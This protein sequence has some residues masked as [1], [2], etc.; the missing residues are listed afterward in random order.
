M[1]AENNT[2]KIDNHSIKLSH[3]NKILFPKSKISKEDVISY[4]AKI[5]NYFLPFVKDHLIVM[6]RFPDGI[7][8]DGFY[9]KQIPNFF[10]KWIA[11]KQI[12]LKKGEKQSLV[13]IDQKAS[14]VYLANQA[15]LVFH[16]WLS[17]I[18]A[19]KKPD[20]IVFDLDPSGNSL[21]ELRFAARKIKEIMKEHTLNSFVMTTGS[22]GYHVVIPIIPEHSFDKVHAFAKHI[23]HKL[24]EKYKDRFTIEINIAKRKGRIFIDYLRNSY[25]Q[26]SV[27]CY[28]LRAKE[29]AP[30][31]TPLDWDELGKTKPQQYTIKNIFKR[32]AHKKKLPWHD[33]YKKQKKLHL[34]I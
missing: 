19:I 13:L 22:R 3:I 11:R 26:T 4:Y 14:L 32:L 5:A 10:P 2:I 30:V 17:S 6:H 34:D 1:N 24:A 31:A 12:N 18:H 8:K 16:S 7:T 33:F 29:G 9:Q 21:K 27:A 15:V 25:G 20:K 23:A 28:S